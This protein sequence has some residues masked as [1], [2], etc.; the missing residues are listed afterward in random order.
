ML[1]KCWS[2]STVAG[3]IPHLKDTEAGS[4]Q[5]NVAAIKKHLTEVLGIKELAMKF[6]MVNFDLK[7]FRLKRI[8]NGKTG[9]YS[10]VTQQ[11]WQMEIPFLLEDEG[12]S[13]LNGKCQLVFGLAHF[14]EN[15]AT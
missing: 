12:Q 14:F 6:G 13:E 15:S 1:S 7:L 8:S 11:Q 5:S 2:V 4:S 9:N 10:I 3:K